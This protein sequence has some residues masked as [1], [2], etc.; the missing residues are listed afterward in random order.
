M[1]VDHSGEPPG[2][3]VSS[4]IGCTGVIQWMI[5]MFSCPHPGTRAPNSASIRGGGGLTNTKDPE[6]NEEPL[7]ASVITTNAFYL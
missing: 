7:F 4:G 2:I 6:F 5:N 1:Y 3:G